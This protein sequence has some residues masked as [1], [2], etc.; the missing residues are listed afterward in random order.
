[1]KN[2]YNLIFNFTGKKISSRALRRFHAVSQTGEA[3][4]GVLPIIRKFRH[5]LSQ[6]INGRYLLEFDDVP[7]LN[8]AGELSWDPT[9]A[10]DDSK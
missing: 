7:L 5:S 4:A 1:M 10:S 6:H 9:R 8:D 3:I 2:I